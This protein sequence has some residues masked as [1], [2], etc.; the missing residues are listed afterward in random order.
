MPTSLVNRLRGTLLALRAHWQPDN[1]EIK[2][3]YYNYINEFVY[4]GLDFAEAREMGHGIWDQ[5]P[6]VLPCTRHAPYIFEVSGAPQAGEDILEVGCGL[7]AVA[8]YC[9]KHFPQ[10]NSYTAVDLDEGNIADC[11]EVNQ[12]PDRLGFYT[13]DATKLASAPF[14]EVRQRAM[15]GFH[16][17]FFL[18]VT[19]EL[20]TEQFRNIFDQSIRMLRPGGFLMIT[21]LTL[22]DTPTGA[23][24]EKIEYM[25]RL[26][27][28][29]LGEIEEAAADFPC[30]IEINEITDISIKAFAN[31][32]N[33]NIHLVDE[34]YFP[35]VSSISKSYFRGC[36]SLVDRGA[37]REFDIFVKKS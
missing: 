5:Y 26:D 7:G 19:P 16:R 32:I 14:P 9:A 1:H 27:S 17:I 37:L 15:E 2:Y 25:I 24:E 12:F 11:Q 36:K 10:I 21:A 23:D 6:S 4:R 13:L 29:N 34:A 3:K 18:E 30:I 22:E 28:P 35:P 33:E 31:W 8:L 20:T